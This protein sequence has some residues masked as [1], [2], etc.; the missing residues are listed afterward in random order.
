MLLSV[1]PFNVV[2]GPC[3]LCAYCT[4][5]KEFELFKVLFRKCIII[6]NKEQIKVMTK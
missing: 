3:M 4:N 6:V 2:V 5:F 1:G